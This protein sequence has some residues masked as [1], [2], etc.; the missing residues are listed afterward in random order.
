MNVLVNN[1]TICISNRAILRLFYSNFYVSE[2]PLKGGISS[3]ELLQWFNEQLFYYEEEK[4]NAMGKKWSSIKIRLNFYTF[5]WRRRQ[6][7]S[8]VRRGPRTPSTTPP[9]TT[10]P[11]L[12]HVKRKLF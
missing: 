8:T 2:E 9:P 6:C 12:C 1:I 3:G 4:W 5:K 10:P 11:Q 7:Y